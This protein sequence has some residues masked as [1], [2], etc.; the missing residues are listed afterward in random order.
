MVTLTQLNEADGSWGRFLAEWRAQ[1]EAQGEDFEEYAAGSM[2]VL[3]D[4]ACKPEARAGVFAL[5][6]DG[7]FA[8]VCQANV[9]MLPGFDG[10]VLRI[11]MMVLAPDYDLGVKPIE[12][13]ARAIVRLLLG[14]ISLS[15]AKYP[16]RYVNFHLRSPND[17]A[18]FTAVGDSLGTTSVFAA[19]QARG[20]WLYVTKRQ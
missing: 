6:M 17:R 8:A 7:S 9:A 4:L 3:A 16:A 12:E 19:V 15:D 5:E 14:A 20:G 11:R 13:Y 2:A 1:C 10:P 18:F